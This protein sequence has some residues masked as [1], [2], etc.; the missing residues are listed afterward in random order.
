[1]LVNTVE[2]RETSIRESSAHEEQQPIFSRNILTD[3]VQQH[4]EKL[5][6]RFLD[7]AD[8]G[9]NVD[10]AQA[11]AVEKLIIHYRNIDSCTLTESRPCRCLPC[12]FF[13]FQAIHRQTQ[14]SCTILVLTRA[15]T[16]IEK[17]LRFILSLR[18]K[19]SSHCHLGIIQDG[20]YKVSNQRHTLMLEDHVDLDAG[21]LGAA[22]AVT[23]VSVSS[24]KL[25][26]TNLPMPLGHTPMWSQGH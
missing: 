11:C 5:G 4:L 6:L 13:L 1:M 12:L 10:T 19:K 17:A 14:F 9:T 25:L 18:N 16:W 15:R 24:K 22:L 20:C 7:L 23:D 26:P 8:G 2:T 21:P 3:C